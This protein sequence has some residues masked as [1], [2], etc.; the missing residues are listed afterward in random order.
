[1]K[2]KLTL[3]LIL[4]LLTLQFGCTGIEKSDLSNSS[5]VLTKRDRPKVKFVFAHNWCGIPKGIC[6]VIEYS[7]EDP[8]GDDE[9][10]A[11]LDVLSNQLKFYPNKIIWDQNG[12]V[13][14]TENVQLSNS[15]CASLGISNNSYITTGNYSI[16]T[17]GAVTTVTVNY[18]N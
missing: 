9:A 12:I 1:M 10:V 14:V 11:E 8:V 16:N 17:S 18:S 2:E 15:V 6:V 7:S 5:G 13:P 4:L 3:F